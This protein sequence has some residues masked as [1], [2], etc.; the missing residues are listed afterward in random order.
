M[1]IFK[2]IFHV[3]VVCSL[4][5]LK[6]SIRSRNNLMIQIPSKRL[7]NAQEKVKRFLYNYKTFH[8]KSYKRRIL[9]FFIGKSRPS[10][11]AA[12]K[13]VL[14]IEIVSQNYLEHYIFFQA[15][16]WVNN[17]LK[18]KLKSLIDLFIQLKF[19][20][21]RQKRSMLIKSNAFQTG[22]LVLNE[23][24]HRHFQRFCYKLAK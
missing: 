3:I 14:F 22:A 9:V 12:D 4:I 21:T 19:S 2:V 20:L 24:F 23:I 7:L 17:F 18:M 1:K 6:R 13:P 11:S 10:K 5:E 8:S 15:R 16:I